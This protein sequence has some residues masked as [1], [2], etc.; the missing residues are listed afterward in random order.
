MWTYE[1]STGILVTT[2]RCDG[3]L[4]HDDS[5]EH[6]GAAS[7]GCIIMSRDVRWKVWE[8]GDH[9]HSLKVVA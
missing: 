3:F 9:S 8:Y 2:V 5:I 7:K 6:P 4:M 1:Q